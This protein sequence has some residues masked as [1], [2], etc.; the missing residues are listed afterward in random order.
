MGKKSVLD[1]PVLDSPDQQSVNS[2]REALD[3]DINVQEIWELITQEVLKIALKAQQ[4]DTRGKLDVNDQVR[5]TNI[6]I[7]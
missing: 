1:S 6:W 4:Q 3:R 7:Y 5:E 2:L